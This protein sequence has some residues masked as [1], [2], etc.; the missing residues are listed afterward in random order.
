MVHVV[1]YIA[2]V[3]LAN[4]AFTIIPPLSLPS[5]DIWSPVALVVGFTFV[6]RDYA[7]RAI[8]HWVL[9]AMLAGGVISWFFASPQIAVASTCAFLLGEL[10]D[11]LMFTFTRRPFADRILLSS[12]ISTP[13]DSAV[14]LGMVGIFSLPSVALMTLS[15]MLGAFIVYLCARKRDNDTPMPAV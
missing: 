13:I 3:V 11:W 12:L 8:G 6:V 10:V 1:L 9:A 4:Y 14:F 7:Q 15:K 5:G 2:T